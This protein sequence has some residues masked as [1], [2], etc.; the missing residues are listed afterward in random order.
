VAKG[1]QGERREAFLA[2]GAGSLRRDAV[3][4]PARC[5]RPTSSAPGVGA[6]SGSAGGELN[7]G[8][9]AVLKGADRDK[10]GGVD[11]YEFDDFMR[12]GG[13]DSR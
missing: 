8:G 5:S 2:Y 9:T 10:D 7:G 12:R 1:G 4:R 6:T 13:F 3:C 11:R